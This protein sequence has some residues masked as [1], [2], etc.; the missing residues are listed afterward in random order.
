MS[1]ELAEE[2]GKQA[3]QK[4]NLKLMLNPTAINLK[5]FAKYLLN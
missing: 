5:G 4:T 1:G 3:T 2:R